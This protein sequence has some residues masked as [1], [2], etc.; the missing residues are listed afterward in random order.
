MIG[1]TDTLKKN[2]NKLTTSDQEELLNFINYKT[3]EFEDAPDLPTV[4]AI[5]EA[6]V[7]AE[8]ITPQEKE[9]LLSTLQNFL[10]PVENI[11]SP[12][13][14]AD[15]ESI[16][17]T[18]IQP[19]NPQKVS[20]ASTETTEPSALSTLDND[21]PETKEA[22]AVES[23]AVDI[24]SSEVKQTTAATTSIDPVLKPAQG[25]GAALLKA[26][27]YPASVTGGLLW[28]FSLYLLAPWL[29]VG[30]LSSI[31][32][33]DEIQNKFSTT[34][35][36]ILELADIQS[37]I[38]T[39]RINESSKFSVWEEHLKSIAKAVKTEPQNLTDF[40]DALKNIHCEEAK[41][42]VSAEPTKDLNKSSTC[43]E[44]AKALNN[45]FSYLKSEQDAE[46]ELKTSIETFERN[47]K[48][49]DGRAVSASKL[50]ELNAR[51]EFMSKFYYRDM[52]V[53]PDQVLTLILAIAMG[54]LGSTITMTWTFLAE[55][56]NPPF[57]WYL[58]RPFVGAISALV[59]FIMAKAGQMTLITESTGATLSPFVL[60][61]LG[62]AAGLLSDRA[63]A[64]MS[65]VSGKVLGDIGAE[66][67][68][69][70]SHLVK[71]IESQNI[72]PE[73]L[74]TALS[75]DPA[76]IAA[77]ISD[78]QPAS[79]LEQRRISDRL[80]IAPRLL[81]TDIPPESSANTQGE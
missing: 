16:I 25:P 9:D 19:A 77:I 29:A 1:L 31:Q 54:I 76:R 35:P 48:P 45:Y 52:L 3:G 64:Q 44:L 11:S 65:S 69:W 60:S 13:S 34:L 47:T 37:S 59:I 23:D 39:Q 21:L 57:R 58:L 4:D 46:K 26:S 32:F 8:S 27:T 14:Q 2:V 74:A 78:Q 55:K 15:S 71:E 24:T 6:A 50:G 5:L 68:R 66:Q 80:G 7:S 49:A 63:Y 67:K 43:A 72:T 22:V 40:V 41:S 61:L 30:S 70:S 38:K 56:P 81:F 75:M 20:E 73:Q 53:M 79:L 36:D 28:I 18:K 42:G 10:T 51:I 62:I 12:P 17:D 33:R